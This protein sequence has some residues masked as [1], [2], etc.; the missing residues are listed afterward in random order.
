MKFLLDTNAI[1][2]ERRTAS[3]NLNHWIAGQVMADLAISSITLLEL[4]FGIRRR[5]EQTPPRE[6]CSASGSKTS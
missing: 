4:E 3:R 6:L 2:D 1:S 5:S